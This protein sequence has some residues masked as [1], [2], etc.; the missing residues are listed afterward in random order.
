MEEYGQW[1]PKTDRPMALRSPISDLRSSAFH[2]PDSVSRPQPPAPER[3]RRRRTHVL[4]GLTR[5][6]RR[7]RT[8]PLTALASRPYLR[9]LLRFIASA[10]LRSQRR[11]DVG[12]TG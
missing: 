7:Y 5:L 6:C 9:Y 11:P 8:R 4:G 10:S 12:L 3:L 1:R 2:S